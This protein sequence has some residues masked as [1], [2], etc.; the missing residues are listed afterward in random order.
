[1]TES[2]DLLYTDYNDRSVNIAKEDKIQQLVRLE[3]WRPQSVC[4]SSSGDMLVIM[5]SDDMK[6]TKLVRFSGSKEKQTIQ[7]DGRRQPIF[8]L[9]KPN[10]SLRE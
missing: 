7:W 1:M 10:V 9:W 2:G 5:T 8:F 3:E 6:E 4:N